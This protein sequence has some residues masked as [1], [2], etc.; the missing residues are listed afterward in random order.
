M[1]RLDNKVAI[2]T[3]G[4]MGLGEA[5]SRAFI[6]EGAKVWITDINT[7]KGETLANELGENAR[8]VKQDVR[9]EAGWQSLI[10]QVMEKD[11]QL[12]ILVNNAG[13]VEAGTIENHSIEDFK[14]VM[15][16]S[17]EGTF[18]GCKHA[19]P[20]IKASGTGSIINMASIASLQGAPN[21]IGY[22]AA[23]GAIEAMT[24]SIA[25]YCIG[26]KYKIRCNSIHPSGIVT[27][28][29]MSMR[30]KI[31]NKKMEAQPT[32][33]DGSTSKLGDPSDIANTVVFLA[34]DESRF[35][36][37]TEI[38]VDNGISAVSAV[39]PD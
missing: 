17:A 5:D 9:D 25:A 14:F 11:G 32:L 34:S 29:V 13:T 6:A 12:D 27:P 19:I 24:R 3:G 35:I 15:A 31:D 16:V 33:L 30:E 28:M 37:G 26:K 1:K 4:S 22:S 23:K 7:E 8:F 20:A 18:L 39:V 21:V 36:N 38:R 2:V 10:A